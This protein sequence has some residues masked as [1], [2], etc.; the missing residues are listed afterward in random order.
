MAR[1]LAQ[2]ADT[3]EGKDGADY[4][5][6]ACCRRSGHM[7]EGWLEF[8]PVA[9]GHVLRTSR[10][11]TQPNFQD[12]DYWAGGLTHVYLEGARARAEDPLPA[13]PHVTP[14]GETPAYGGP[15]H[16]ILDPFSVFAKGEGL[17][18]DEL[19]AFSRRHLVAII[20]DY[21]L[22]PES[23][24]ALALRDDQGLIDLIVAGVKARIRRAA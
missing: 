18:R 4:R 13:S 3:V 5:A 8:V 21:D 17:L 7:W 15:R 9:G 22:G 6:R 1:V 23:G 16:A 14:P 11:T 19:S 10:E 2:F 24:P 12:I 20:E